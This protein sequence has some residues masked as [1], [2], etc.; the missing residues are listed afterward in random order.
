MKKLKNKFS[1]LFLVSL[2][3]IFLPIQTHAAEPRITDILIT[4]DV[5]NVLL[6]ARLINGFK[7][8]MELAVLAG[9]P[10]NFVMWLEVYQERPLLWDKKITQKEIKRTMKYDNLKKTFSVSTNKGE[11][12]VFSDFESAQKAMS[13]FNGIIAAPMSSLA[14]GGNYYVMIKIKMD[15][16]RLPLHM[17][18]IFFLVSLWDFETSWYK[19]KFSY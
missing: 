8:D 9:I 11:Q 5:E 13:D 18:N 6:Y 17:E 19:Q 4:N 15:K 2:L 14:K 7:P 10:A 16:V 1:G 12:V 3:I